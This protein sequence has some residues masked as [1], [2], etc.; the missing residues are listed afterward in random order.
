MHPSRQSQRGGRDL[1][2]GT[3]LGGLPRSDHQGRADEVTLRPN[4]VGTLRVFISTEHIELERWRP[5]LVDA[6][7][8]AFCQA[9][10]K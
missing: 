9:V 4:E 1:C 3:R 7:G 6:G 10:Y 2:E 8:H 5:L